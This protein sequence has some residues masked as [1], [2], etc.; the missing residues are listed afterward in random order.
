MERRFHRCLENNGDIDFQWD[1]N[2]GGGWG[3]AVFPSSGDI[4]GTLISIVLTRNT[5]IYVA[6]MHIPTS[7]GSGDNGDN[8]V[9]DS[10]TF[11][12]IKKWYNFLIS[13]QILTIKVSFFS[14][15]N[16]R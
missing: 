4:G 7:Q 8:G 16:T 2:R 15:F 5:D 10:S 1:E 11:K 14:A 3:A 6:A 9:P 13:E 12:I